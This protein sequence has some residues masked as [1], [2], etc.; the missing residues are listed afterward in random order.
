[1]IAA[2]LHR[3]VAEAGLLRSG[4]NPLSPVDPPRH[5]PGARGSD[6]SS[7]RRLLDPRGRRGG[8]HRP[9]SHVRG[10]ACRSLLR[11]ALTLC[12]I[13]SATSCARLS[14][15]PADSRDSTPAHTLEVEHHLGFAGC[16]LDAGSLVCE[17]GDGYREHVASGGAALVSA[18]SYALGACALSID[19]KVHCWSLD[20]AAGC[21][22]GEPETI[23]LQNVVQVVSGLAGACALT[24]SGET[25][26][27][28][29]DSGSASSEVV[30]ASEPRRVRGL[31]SVQLLAAED[32]LTCGLDRDET[33]WCWGSGYGRAH[34]APTRVEGLREVI[35]IASESFRTCALRTDDSVWC[36]GRE[37]SY[38]RGGGLSSVDPVRVL[39]GLHTVDV[40]SSRDFTCALSREGA[41]TCF[42]VGAVAAS[43]P[44]VPPQATYSV[45]RGDPE[46]AGPTPTVV[47]EGVTHQT[48]DRH[49]GLT[50][51]TARGEAYCN[52]L[53]SVRLERGLCGD[54]P[55]LP[56]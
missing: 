4:E 6:G 18:V 53:N 51:V 50:L 13:G 55:R 2:E 32:S 24:A 14:A 26:C 15:G 21:P 20:A 49:G 1:M 16:T 27:W 52:G 34:E 38:G 37:M 36:W 29:V 42:G 46:V 25:Y 41:V 45:Q 33:V 54:L 31:P 47:A 8:D 43:Q 3:R 48:V 28:G 30:P 39:D 11:L 35:D 23:P 7:S 22:V 17:C 12:V 40:D 44:R 10:H 9:V 56:R 5:R 19:R